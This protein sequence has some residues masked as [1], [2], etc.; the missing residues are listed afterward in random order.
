[1]SCFNY[2]RKCC[3]AAAGI[4]ATAAAAAKNSFHL[5]VL[6]GS[7]AAAVVKQCLFDGLADRQ[8]AVSVSEAASW[9]CSSYVKQTWTDMLTDMLFRKDSNKVTG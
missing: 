8:A 1:V 6:D 5:L 7:Q 2:L 3:A 4:V 9:C